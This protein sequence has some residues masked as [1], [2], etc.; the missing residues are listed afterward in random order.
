MYSF[1]KVIDRKNTECAK[2]D[3]LP[4]E[5]VPEVH[6]PLWVADMDF[7]I[8]PQ[9]VEA[10]NKRMEHKLFGYFL[11]TDR[12][13]DSII[14]WHSRRYDV[15]DITKENICY[16]N[17]VLAGVAHA[18]QTLTKEG[19]SIIVQA[20]TYPGF[21]K[22]VSN[23][24]RE[25][26]YN[27]M[28]EDENGYFTIDLQDF[29]NK[30]VEKNIK[31]F[32]FCNPHNPSG[33]IWTKEEMVSL[34]DICL[35]HDVKIISDEIWSDVI[36]NK[37]MHHL[38]LC[39]AD[40]RAKDI[41]ISMYSPSKGYSLAGMVSSYSVCYNKELAES[42]KTTSYYL[43]CNSP[44][45]LAVDTT[46]AA[47]DKAEDWLDSCNDYVGANMDFILGFIAEKL[48]KIKCRK[49]D[50]TYLLWLD[51][52][53]LGITHEEMIKRAVNEAGVV[54]NNGNDFVLGGELHMR[55][56]P[57][58]ARENLVKAMNALEKAFSDIAK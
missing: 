2:F 41:T 34:V 20:P 35:K 23:M 30:I 49:P 46:I 26:V 56:N 3:Y 6:Y 33:R 1:D 14:N 42:L 24:N 7:E 38:P 8:A 45:V 39:K 37:E 15:K 28:K 29:E 36:I 10:L 57:T 11:M 16:Q 53:A 21:T 44:C 22:T 12:Y 55:L 54:M 47:Y 51:F 5:N 50:A 48:P 9:I 19:D 13:F 43:H 25:L 17:G 4:Y 40:P 32:I 18:V 52:K 31:L 27:L 58:T